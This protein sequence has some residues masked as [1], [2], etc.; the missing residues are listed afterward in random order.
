MGQEKQP[1]FLMLQQIYSVL[2]SAIAIFCPVLGLSDRRNLESARP[3]WGHVASV[4]QYRDP[5][6]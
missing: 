2:Q 5:S 3:E 4:P 6:L 1:V